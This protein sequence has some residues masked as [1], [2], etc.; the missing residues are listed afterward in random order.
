MFRLVAV[1]NVFGFADGLAAFGRNLLLNQNHLEFV[2]DFRDS[3]VLLVNGSLVDLLLPGDT[4]L[5]WR[6]LDALFV[7]AVV[8]RLGKM[9]VHGS[10]R[11]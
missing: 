5:D 1:I 11:E 10:A 7:A 2:P 3:N 8:A 9:H 6:A 4:I